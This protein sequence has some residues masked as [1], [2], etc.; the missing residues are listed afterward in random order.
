M[1]ATDPSGLADKLYALVPE[2]GSAI[3]NQ[4]LRHQLSDA[5]RS[6]VSEAAYFAARD[7]LLAAGRLVKG[8]GR[9]GAVQQAT[10]EE[11]IAAPPDATRG[12]LVLPRNA[13]F[14]PFS[15]Y[16]RHLDAH[17]LRMRQDHAGEFRGTG[18]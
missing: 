18:K 3:G 6:E 2:D 12:F 4:A 10:V 15:G 8:Q 9:G 1:P 7:A 17:C 5:M 13:R 11:F 14:C 16:S